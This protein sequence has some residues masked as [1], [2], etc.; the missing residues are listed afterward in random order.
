M[1]K[2]PFADYGLISQ[3]FFYFLHISDKHISW[4][5]AL[6][7]SRVIT[8][9]PKIFSGNTLTMVFDS[10]LPNQLTHNPIDGDLPMNSYFFTVLTNRLACIAIDW[11]S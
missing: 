11:C 9:S 7:T 10:D 6:N 8:F 3:F 2:Y 5:M 4:L 1:F